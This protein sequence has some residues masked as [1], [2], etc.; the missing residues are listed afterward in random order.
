MVNILDNLR[1]GYGV[2]CDRVRVALRT[3][4]GDETRLRLHIGEV[5]S[6]ANAVE[7][8]SSLL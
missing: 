7:M 8:V 3:Q 1:A 2:L 5:G 4:V 6:L